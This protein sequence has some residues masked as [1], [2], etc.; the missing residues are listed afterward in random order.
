MKKALALAIATGIL[1]A[2]ATIGRAKLRALRNAKFEIPTATVERG[3]LAVKVY[4]TGALAAGHSALLLA[5]AVSGGNLRIVRLLNTGARVEEGGVVVAFDPT[6]QEHALEQAR[7]DL[8][9]AEQEIIKAKADAAVQAATDQT[10]LLSDRFD[11]RRAKLTAGTN[12]LVSPIDAK[13]NIL[14][15]NQ[16]KPALAQL[17]SDIKS[18]TVSGQ[19]TLAVSEQKRQ[20]ALLAMQLAQRNIDSMTVRSPITGLVEVKQNEMAYGGIFIEGM[21]LPEYHAGDSTYPGMP[22]AEVIDPTEIDIEAKVGQSDRANIKIGKPAGIT[23]SALPGSTFRGHIKTIS[24][25]A[26]RGSFFFQ[27]GAAPT[28]GLTIQLERTDSSLR[29][30]YQA[31]IIISANPLRNVLYLPPQAVFQQDGNP[32]VYVK[33]GN[34]F[35]ARPVKITYRTE[36]HDVVE[37]LTRGTVVALVNPEQRPG[38]ARA[39]SPQLSSTFAGGGL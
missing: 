17:Q 1:A 25:V 19:A 32:V 12:A 27:A 6:E 28:F 14:T 5:P 29:P 8:E 20:K 33:R 7:T 16:A 10:Q 11:V 4:T 37:G 26:S 2:A 22:V 35:Q 38:E 24:S 34:S 30:G 31:Q 21:P 15:L 23:V 39:A 13:K 3:D 9:Q 18:H 36:T